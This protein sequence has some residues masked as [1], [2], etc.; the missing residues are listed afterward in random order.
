MSGFSLQQ[1]DQRTV[2]VEVP[3]FEKRRVMKGRAR[4]V[5]H[6]GHGATALHVAVQTPAESFEFIFDVDQF[7]GSIEHG[8]P[9]ACDYAIRL[10]AA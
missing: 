9:F 4:L 1:L 2:A 10:S 6:N 7:S 5:T 8:E 3:F